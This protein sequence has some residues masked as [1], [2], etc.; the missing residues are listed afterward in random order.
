MVRV[1]TLDPNELERPAARKRSLYLPES[2]LLR[3][4]KKIENL[5]YL[6]VIEIFFSSF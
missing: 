6:A 5:P 1:R 4:E 3:I 2:G